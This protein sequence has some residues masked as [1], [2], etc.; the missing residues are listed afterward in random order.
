MN[1]AVLEKLDPDEVELTMMGIAGPLGWEPYPAVAA[2]KNLMAP[3]AI[4]DEP[5][6]AK[7]VYGKSSE[8]FKQVLW[9][10]LLSKTAGYLDTE[11]LC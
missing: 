3:Q 10:D 5:D 6:L 2:W 1:P 7:F 11:G 8:E 9:S 4:S